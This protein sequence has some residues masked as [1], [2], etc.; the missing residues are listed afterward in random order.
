MILSSPKQKTGRVLD[1]SLHERAERQGKSTCGLETVEEQVAIFDTASVAEQLILLRDTVKRYS[2]LPDLFTR[3]IDRY[4][5]RDLAGLLTLSQESGP[6]DAAVKR[7]FDVFMQRLLDQRNP[8][9]LD[10][11]DAAIRAGG[12]FIAVGALH[13]PGEQ[14]LLRLLHQQGYALEAVY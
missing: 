8:R 11:M 13:L 1:L 14:G 2:Q 10:R 3:L 7:V 9:L 5:A 6:T 12:A 4:L